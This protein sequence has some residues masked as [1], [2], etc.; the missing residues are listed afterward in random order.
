MWLSLFERKCLKGRQ[1]IWVRRCCNN[2][3]EKESDTFRNF[4]QY[5]KISC[6]FLLSFF[7]SIVG[8]QRP[9]SSLLLSFFSRAGKGATAHFCGHYMQRQRSDSAFSAEAPRDLLTSAPDPR[10]LILSLEPSC[11]VAERHWMVLK[12]ETHARAGMHAE[13]HTCLNRKNTTHSLKYTHIQCS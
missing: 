5:E 2:S 9:L 10:P 13:L 3:H 6:I 8:S 12:C 4:A 1:I 7:P 11:K